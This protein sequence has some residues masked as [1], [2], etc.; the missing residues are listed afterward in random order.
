MVDRIRFYLVCILSDEILSA[1]KRHSFVKEGKEYHYFDFK[2]ISFLSKEKNKDF[3]E[4]EKYNFE[5]NDTDDE[6]YFSDYSY[7][8][9]LIT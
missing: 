4:N 3:P 1:K 9:L 8:N 2:K 6:N 7:K 5:I